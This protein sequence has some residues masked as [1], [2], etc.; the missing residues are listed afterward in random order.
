MAVSPV[1]YQLVVEQIQTFSTGEQ[2]RLIQDLI[3]IVQQRVVDPS[4]LS[5]LDLQGLGKDSWHGVNVDKYIN[6]ERESWNG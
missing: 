3:G 2:L 1:A 6:E 5:P 4:A